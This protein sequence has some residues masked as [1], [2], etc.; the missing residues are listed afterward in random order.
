LRSP[1]IP[2]FLTIFVD[3]LAL[4]MMLPLLPYYAKHF[5]ASD[6]AAAALTAVFA[7]C[8]LISGPILGSASDKRG[9]KPVLVFSQIGTCAALVVLALSGHLWMVFASRALAGLTAGNLTVAQAYISDVTKPEDRTKA[10]GLFGIAFGVGFIIGPAISGSMAKHFGYAAPAWLAAGLSGLSI[11]TTVALLPR[12]PVRVVLPTSDEPPRS[13]GFGRG[14]W[15]AAAIRRFMPLV[16]YLRD[17]APR[18]VLLAFGGFLLSFSTLLSGLA[19]FLRGRFGYD[20]QQTALIF[21]FSGVV[22][23]LA[24]PLLGLLSRQLGEARLVRIGL[25]IT[26]VGY[27][28]LGV[29]PN[30]LPLYASVAVTS[31]GSAFVR[32]AATTLLTRAVSP[33]EAGAVLGAN[34]TVMSL[35]QIVGPILAGM[36]VERRMYVLYGVAAGG[37]AAIG[38]LVTYLARGFGAGAPGSRPGGPSTPLPRVESPAEDT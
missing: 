13:L 31:V 37:F 17:P 10:F 2:I 5:G 1:L 22:G 16:I 8:Q 14:S 20:V 19:L 32:P 23:A 9:R 11:V 15:W 29:I 27:A 36:L 30:G 21:G 4:T 26:A 33:G 12:N 25:A 24:Q 18:G 35:T 3:I 7:G 28:G 38:L 34:Q 6:F